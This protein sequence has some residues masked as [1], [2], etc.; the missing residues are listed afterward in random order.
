MTW[1]MHM[2]IWQENIN[3]KDK[4]MYKQFDFNY[5]KKEKDIKKTYLCDTS[6]KQNK[7]RVDGE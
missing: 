3:T 4:N 5:W 7:A 6:E 1:E 2:M